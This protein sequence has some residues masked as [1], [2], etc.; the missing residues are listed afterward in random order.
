MDHAAVRG[1]LRHLSDCEAAGPVRDGDDRLGGLPLGGADVENVAT[2]KFLLTLEVADRHR[3][4]SG[5]SVPDSGRQGALERIPAKDAQQERPPRIGVRL[6]RATR[7]N[8]SGYRAWRLS[9]RI[10]PPSHSGRRQSRSA[11]STQQETARPPGTQLELGPFRPHRS[12]V[13]VN[14]AAGDRIEVLADRIVYPIRK[15]RPGHAIG[16]PEST[17]DHHFPAADSL[18]LQ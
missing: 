16:L 1:E 11:C 3:P 9:A 13:R 8:P 15:A 10:H 6:R 12:Q 5:R 17:L 2:R 14:R 18:R 7:R 4:D